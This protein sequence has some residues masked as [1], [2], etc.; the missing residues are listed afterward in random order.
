MHNALG[1]QGAEIRDGEEE[2]DVLVAEE[3]G[4]RGESEQ[5]RSKRFSKHRTRSTPAA[6]RS[7]RGNSGIS[8]ENGTF[9]AKKW[10]T[11]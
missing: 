4:S 6:A 2:E 3:N 1:V 8:E 10:R 9:V 7:K 11:A 5:R